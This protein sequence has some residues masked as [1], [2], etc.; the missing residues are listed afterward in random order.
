[1]A[2]RL[3]KRT[4]HLAIDGYVKCRALTEEQGTVF[5]AMYTRCRSPEEQEQVRKAVQEQLVGWKTGDT[6]WDRLLQNLDE[7]DEDELPATAAALANTR[8]FLATR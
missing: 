5:R 4:F 8:S 2:L 3:R 1:M 7:D 6:T